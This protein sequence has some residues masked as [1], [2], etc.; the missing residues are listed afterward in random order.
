MGI[1]VALVIFLV[2]VGTGFYGAIIGSSLLVV[3][4]VLIFFGL[5]AHTALGTG[6]SACLFRDITAFW[7]YHRHGFVRYRE[8][9]IFTAVAALSSAFGTYWALSLEARSIEILISIFMAVVGGIILVNPGAGLIARKPLGGKKALVVSVAS[10]A[11]VG[12]YSGLFG[13]GVNVF[14]IITFVVVFGH[15]FLAAVS[16]AK[17]PNIITSIVS[18]G[19]FASS[20]HVSYR[21]AL[22]L[23]FG[24]IVGAAFG[25]RLAVKRGNR[26]IRLLFV[27]LVFALALTL[28]LRPFS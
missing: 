21:F 24:M 17:I 26:F 15:D 4:P 8:G 18:A 5:P 27:L 28:F 7:T 25:A 14:V 16:T 10:G 2:G 3:V 12:F 19:I 1:G 11:V 23:T 6:K 9:V 22:P 13:G 20:G